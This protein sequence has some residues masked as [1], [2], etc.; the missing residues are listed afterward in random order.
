MKR[1]PGHKP[2]EVTLLPQKAPQ[3]GSR[4]E[5]ALHTLRSLRW[6]DKYPHIP[7]FF[8]VTYRTYL[9]DNKSEKIKVTVKK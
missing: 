3:T 8:F 9:M 1:A 6:E 7:M 5:G 2:S 4:W